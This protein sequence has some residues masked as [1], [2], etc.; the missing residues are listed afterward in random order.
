[1][2]KA[3]KFKYKIRQVTFGNKTG[4]SFAITVPRNIA[5]NFSNITFNMYMTPTS[6]IFE[7]GCSVVKKGVDIG[8][9]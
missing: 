3:P 6:I 8:T 2:P 7:S 9:K 4:E 1:M 5:E